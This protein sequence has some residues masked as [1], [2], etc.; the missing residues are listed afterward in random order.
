MGDDSHQVPLSGNGT[1]TPSA[2]ARLTPAPLDFG[3][4]ALEKTAVGTVTIAGAGA[5]PLKTSQIQ[6]TGEGASDFAAENQCADSELQPGAECRLQVRFTPRSQGQHVARLSISNNAGNSPQEI[7]LIGYGV[8]LPPPPPPPGSPGGGKPPVNHNQPPGGGTSPLP[9][10]IPLVARVLAHPEEARFGK[11]EVRTTSPAQRVTLTSV[12]TGPAQVQGFS[13]QGPSP[14]DFS[15]GDVNCRGRSLAPRDE[16]ALT[17]TFVPQTS[18]LGSSQSDRT[19]ELRHPDRRSIAFTCPPYRNRDG[20]TTGGTARGFTVNPTEIAFGEIQVGMQ[21]SGRAVTLT[22]PGTDPI[23]LR[24]SMQAGGR[25]DFRV[26]SGDCR[27]ST[28]P[29]RGSCTIVLAF[30][31]QGPGNMQADLTLASDSPVQIQPVR[32]SG[33]GLPKSVVTGFTV[34]PRRS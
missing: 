33:T 34:E 3:K 5:A 12:G 8:M 13:L 25:G 24:A 2:G 22:N 27:N 15:V 29:A 14:Q 18:S 10:A 30:S 32:L 7:A 31:P 23:Q 6:I 16:C 28:I 26:L 20:S 11:Q 1:V 9:P 19:A 21:T 17:V 4:Q